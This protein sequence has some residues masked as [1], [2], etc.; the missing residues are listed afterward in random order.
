MRYTAFLVVHLAGA[1]LLSLVVHS[2]ALDQQWMV[3]VGSLD[4]IPCESAAITLELRNPAADLVST[5]SVPLDLNVVGVGTSAWTLRVPKTGEYTLQ[6]ID[7]GCSDEARTVTRIPV[8]ISEHGMPDQVVLLAT[9][10]KARWRLYYFGVTRRLSGIGI[11]EFDD[12]ARRLRN[13]SED[14][15]RT[16]T[17]MLG[18]PVR[19]LRLVGDKW[20]EGQQYEYVGEE[21]ALSPGDSVRFTLP[22]V[23]VIR[24]THK[25]ETD[26]S[27][28]PPGL[29]ARLLE[30]KTA[31][32][33]GTYAYIGKPP[34]GHI[35]DEPFIGH[36]D[37]YVLELAVSSGN[38]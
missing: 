4:A 23:R 27:G 1:M 25:D 36:C 16:C 17:L 19:E 14:T 13:I 18:P 12:E 10:N 22:R 32:P 11:L 3:T 6:A 5:Y 34:P 2:A 33:T 20:E 7:H 37:T 9:G 29:L 15:I 35:S 28:E 8:Q 31:P 38:K 21:R 30:A 24:A 26:S